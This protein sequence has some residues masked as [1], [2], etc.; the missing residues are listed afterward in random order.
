MSNCGDL[1]DRYSGAPISRPRCRLLP[2]AQAIVVWDER[3]TCG[4]RYCGSAIIDSSDRLL[5]ARSLFH[6]VR[7]PLVVLSGGNDPLF[8]EKVPQSEAEVMR[9][10]LVEQ[11][12][13]LQ[14]LGLDP[15]SRGSKKRMRSKNLSV[16]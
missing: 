6:A 5:M 9:R 16:V 10:L 15:Q 2:L 14:K 8:T 1:A 13:R 3:F 11:R 7:T 4:A 12:D